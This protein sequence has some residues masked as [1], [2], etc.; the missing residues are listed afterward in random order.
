MAIMRRWLAI[1]LGEIFLS[2]L[3]IAIAPTFLNSKTPWLGFAIWLAIPCMVGGSVL[4]VAMRSLEAQQAHHLFCKTCPHWR[5]SVGPLDFLDIPLETVK[6]T[7]PQLQAWEET[8]ETQALHLSP[9]D[10]LR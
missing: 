3:L 1:A 7:L 9:L 10:L 8:D 2:L 4:H 6:R 5:E